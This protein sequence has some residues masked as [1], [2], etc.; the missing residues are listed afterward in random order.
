MNI[1]KIKD[2]SIKINIF[3]V[4]MFILYS[5]YGYFLETLVMVFTV[6]L[7]EVF[8]SIAARKYDFQIDE[9]EIFPFGGMAKF[10]SNRIINPSKEIFVCFMGPLSNLIVV[11]IFSIF[12]TI[13]IDSYLIDYIIKVNKLM[14]IINLL[15]V[16]PLD[17]GKI[18]RAILSLFIGYKSSTYKLVYITYFLCTITILYDIFNG[19]A[20]D[21]TYLGAIAV[22]TIVAAKKEK[23][24]AAFAFI[25][26][27]TRKPSEINKEKKMKA[28]ILVCIKTINIKETYECF[29]PNKYHIL[30]IINSNGE[31][32]GTMTESQLLDGI[33]KYGFD[34]TLEELLMEIKK[35]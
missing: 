6:L 8:H 7:H 26:S 29:L 19:I 3:M 15:P 21:F 32:I 30:I 4:I 12:R 33:Y 14:L 24:M 5:L 9:I 34:V 20:G 28:H 31:T 2:I 11:I 18:V 16:F 13:Y 1:L 27:I 35:W 22:F 10:N 17:G 23:E 25:R